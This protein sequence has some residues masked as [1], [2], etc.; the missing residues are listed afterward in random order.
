SRFD[1]ALFYRRTRRFLARSHRLRRLVRGVR[2]RVRAYQSRLPLP[3]GPVPAAAPAQRREEVF[4]ALAPYLAE[5][6]VTVVRDQDTPG[7]EVAV[8]TTAK[9][10]LH[11]ALRRLAEQRADLVVR[12]GTDR[13]AIETLS[14]RRLSFHDLFAAHWLEIGT[15]RERGSYRI[16]ADGYLTVLFVERDPVKNRYLALRRRAGRTDWTP[17]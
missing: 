13:R 3:P 1:P 11:R 12:V 4:A 16:G 6:R 9:R 8:L 10:A 15:P 7:A 14:L 5:E 17:T 2:R